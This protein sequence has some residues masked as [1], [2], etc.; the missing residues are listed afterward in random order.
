MFCVKANKAHSSGLKT[1]QNIKK[2]IRFN[3]L[4]EGKDKNMVFQNVK[5][6]N[7]FIISV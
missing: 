7:H 2:D 4:K 6:P 1:E 3:K 5:E